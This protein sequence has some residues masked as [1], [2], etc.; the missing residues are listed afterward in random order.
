MIGFGD[1]EKW[2]SLEADRCRTAAELLKRSCLI[3]EQAREATWPISG[4]SGGGA[5]RG[6]AAADPCTDPLGI[7]RCSHTAVFAVV[8]A[9]V[10]VG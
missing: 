9:T 4:A 3:P 5:E 10:D 8:T 6:G 1:V 7:S 2:A